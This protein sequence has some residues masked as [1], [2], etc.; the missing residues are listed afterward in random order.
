M[1]MSKQDGIV[2]ACFGL[3]VVILA[4]GW[5]WWQSRPSGDTSTPAK[6]RAAEAEEQVVSELLDQSRIYAIESSGLFNPLVAEQGVGGRAATAS[7]DTTPVSAVDVKTEKT[8]EVTAAPPSTTRG[9]TGPSGPGGPGI[10]GPPPI[11]QPAAIDVAI[12]GIVVGSRVVRV[13]VD[14]NAEGR[15]EWVDVPGKAFGYTVR[16]ATMKGAVL[17]K[18]DRTYVLLLGANKKPRPE[19][20]YKVAGASPGSPGAPGAG[21]SPEDMA[22]MTAAGKM[23][24][25]GMRP[26][27]GYGGGRSGR[28]GG[29]RGG[30]GAPA[31]TMEATR[32]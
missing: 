1:K 7:R 5:I 9:P 30:G 16:Y 2:L 29:G 17:E 13:L 3:A 32:G 23:G 22:K 11:Q 12:T 15:A 25:P 19:S 18:D 14:S 26:P 31:K 10:G 28:M 24:G 21:P 8:V 6:A 4:G 20:D 27:G